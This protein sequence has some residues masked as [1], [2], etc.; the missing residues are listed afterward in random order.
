MRVEKGNDCRTDGYSITIEKEIPDSGLC[1][2]KEEAAK[3]QPEKR[4]Q[5][6][7]ASWLRRSGEKA[8]LKAGGGEKFSL[9]SSAEM[10]PRGEMGNGRAGGSRW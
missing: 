2:K 3:S 8:T 10:K 4:K 1:L 9:L 5:R 6:G 7:C